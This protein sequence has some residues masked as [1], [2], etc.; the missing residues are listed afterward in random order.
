MTDTNTFDIGASL[1]KVKLAEKM[2]ACG[3]FIF[4]A[5]WQLEEK[6]NVILPKILEVLKQADDANYNLRD[7]ISE[8][9][10]N[11]KTPHHESS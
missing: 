10:P 9:A 6:L 1:N 5:P 2:H 7:L 4:N 11:Q 3:M 8:P